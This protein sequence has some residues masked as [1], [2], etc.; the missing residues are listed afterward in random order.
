M[1]ER[2]LTRAR[3]STRVMLWTLLVVYVLF[4]DRQIVNI[5]AE[6]IQPRP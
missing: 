2:V 6:P 4:L 5:L 1:T 3:Q